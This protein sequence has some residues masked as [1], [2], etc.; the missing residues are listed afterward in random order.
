MRKG[1]SIETKKNSE[2]NQAKTKNKND[3]LVTIS[4]SSSTLKLLAAFVL[5]VFVGTIF[6]GDGVDSETGTAN[7]PQ[8]QAAPSAPSGDGNSERV[9]ISADD[10][11]FLGNK[12]AKVTVI[13]FSDFQCPFCQR[14]YSDAVTG[15]K[16][17]YAN[18]GKVKLVY[19]DFPLSFHQE[20]QPAAE[21]AQCANEQGKFWEYHDKLFENQGQL[22]STYYKQLASDL[23]LDTSKFN[24]CL[25]S[26]KFK[27]EVEKDFSDGNRAGVSGTPTFFIGSDA[28]G[29]IKIVGA[30]PFD[31]LKSVIETELAG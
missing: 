26:R 9:Q 24:S 23:K 19:R 29:Y 8:I 12:N 16:R 25:E 3:S 13:E 5:G 7:N 17:D 30:Q 20:A 6:F 31:S 18:T 27:S 21:A 22:S 11:P 2:N 10:D 1:V 4:I 14:A 28:K 15:I